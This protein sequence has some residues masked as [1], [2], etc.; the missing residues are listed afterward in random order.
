MG[1]RQGKTIRPLSRLRGL[2]A[3]LGCALFLAL[4]SGCGKAWGYLQARTTSTSGYAWYGPQA[5]D[6]M[7]GLPDTAAR[8][9]SGLT[10]ASGPKGNGLST[11]DLEVQASSEFAIQSS[12]FWDGTAFHTYGRIY[13]PYSNGGTG[14]A[15]A[16]P[17]FAPLEAMTTTGLSVLSSIGFLDSS[18]AVSF[19]TTST[20]AAGPYYGP[21]NSWG[22]FSQAVFTS[23]TPVTSSLRLS[24]GRAHSIAADN[25]GLMQAGYI[26]AGP[27]TSPLIPEDGVYIHAYQPFLGWDTATTGVQVAT[28]GTQVQMLN[29]GLGATAVWLSGTAEAAAGWAMTCLL[30]GIG[31]VRCWGFDGNGEL[32][33]N[34]G[35][36]T[37]KVVPVWV[38]SESGGGRL[39]NVRQVE[40]GRNH[41]CALKG[42]G[43]AV[44]WGRNSSGELGRGGAVTSAQLYPLPVVGTSGFGILSNLRNVSAG[45]QDTGGPDPGF[46]CAASWD[47][48]A[49]CWGDDT[50][51]EL[52]DGTA[53]LN[54]TSP[55][56]VGSPGTT[57]P[58]T[59]VVQVVAGGAYA[60]ALRSDTTV[61]C[62][63]DQALG[64]L[65]N[66]VVAGDQSAPVQVCNVMGCATFLTGAVKLA[67]GYDHVCALLNTG[68]LSCWGTNTYGQVGNGAI[69][70]TQAVA[71]PVV[72]PGTG[73]V[74]DV[75][76]G[77]DHTCFL[78]WSGATTQAFC[79]GRNHR[80]QL[81]DATAVDNGT[82]QLVAGGANNNYKMITAG[83]FHTCAV[84]TGTSDGQ[85]RCW[86]ANGSGQLGNAAAG[87]GVNS[88]PVTALDAAGAATT[89]RYGVWSAWSLDPSGSPFRQ[90]QALSTEDS[91]LFSAASDQSG[92]VVV[93]WVQRNL[94]IDP[95]SLLTGCDGTTTPITLRGCE[96]RLYG[97]ARGALG[98]WLN[99]TQLDEGFTPAGIVKTT[100]FQDSQGA[101]V[102]STQQYGGIDYATPAVMNLGNDVFEVAFPIID[103]GA[104][105]S[106][107]YTRA[108]N[109]GS[110]WAGSVTLLDQR[111]LSVAGQG[112]RAANDLTS[113][114]DGTGHALLI[115]HHV[116][117]G[118]NPGTALGRSYGFKVLRRDPDAGWLTSAPLLIQ[119]EH[120]CWAPLGPLPIATSGT[121]NYPCW[122]LKAQGA[123]FGTGEA[124]IV[125]PAPS[126]SDATHNT[127]IRLFTMEWRP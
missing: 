5:A 58:L 54:S 6:L 82:P 75:A 29:D 114:T 98:S 103:N 124:V 9:S 73:S 72:A 26:T 74:V 70:G 68:A 105:M 85:M 97:S 80:G 81:G 122:D 11:Y 67:A 110:G 65:G 63:G 53:A 18:S 76:A 38:A 96:Y 78:R 31:Q 57:T 119:N 94:A 20:A 47:G 100:L 19:T 45:G 27:R 41:S 4:N 55:V 64:A 126:S 52:G 10:L 34:D 50:D 56:R 125:F 102:G 30:D 71:Q 21:G 62:W 84:A 25:S 36:G 93:S 99:P 39:S 15:P 14:W 61:W 79:M 104:R 16:G 40:T 120:A 127:N 17:Q 59:G 83:E 116:I 107:V 109:V 111:A 12:S 90:T 48:Y 49:Y 23:A 1:S 28:H 43:T 123:I 115:L 77:R 108:F 66:N 92:N 87:P 2:Q 8:Y 112:Y 117:E 24:N 91:K 3:M 86:G 7:V 69:G 44:C 106:E 51:L 101:I 22:G 32:G 88:S 35:S 13:E 60:C 121:P 95:T 37:T 42:D 46:T 33:D 113:A 89:R 118:Q